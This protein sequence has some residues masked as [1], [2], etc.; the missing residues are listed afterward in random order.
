[1]V[2]IGGAVPCEPDLA[3]PMRDIGRGDIVVSEP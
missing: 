3:Q 1:M 2:G